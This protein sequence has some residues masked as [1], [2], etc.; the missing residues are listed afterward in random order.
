[1]YLL[2]TWTAVI[3]ILN[4]IS[5]NTSN[6]SLNK[7]IRTINHVWSMHFA[8]WIQTC[9]WRFAQILGLTNK[10]FVLVSLNIAGV[11]IAV[12]IMGLIICY[13]IIVPIITNK[14]VVRR[15]KIMTSTFWYVHCSELIRK[16]NT[17]LLAILV[18]LLLKLSCSFA[19]CVC[20]N[21][22]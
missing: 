15:K 16:E 10:V 18:N 13:T 11:S 17:S 14:S 1:M 3:K 7:L 9:W 4:V 6:K 5:K 21:F 12:N 2:R 22:L 20:C 8:F 19:N